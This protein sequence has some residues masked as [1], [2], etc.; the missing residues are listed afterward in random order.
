M[1]CWTTSEIVHIE[2]TIVKTHTTQLQQDKY[3]I[4]QNVENLVVQGW[5]SK[6]RKSQ[7]WLSKNS[8]SH[9]NLDGTFQ[10]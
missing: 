8:K 4:H 9:L 3:Q 10:K 5:I 2:E 6:N 1:N 7:V